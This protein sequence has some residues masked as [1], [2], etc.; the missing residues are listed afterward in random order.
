MGT[1]DKH[2]SAGT[3][4]YYAEVAKKLAPLAERDNRFAY[5]FETIVRLCEFLS[6]KAELGNRLRAA[7]GAGDRDALR[8]IADELPESVERLDCFHTTFRKSFM[9][10]NK[11]FGFQIQDV[12]FGT[13]RA[14]LVYTEQILRDYLSGGVDEIPELLEDTMY[15]DCRPE[16]EE[17]ALHLHL[18]VWSKVAIVNPL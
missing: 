8:A 11:P 2:I 4:A 6:R 7:Y 5:V 3:D 18:P 13:L 15:I 1:Y 9:K 16:D 17:K 14:R 12:R 10:E